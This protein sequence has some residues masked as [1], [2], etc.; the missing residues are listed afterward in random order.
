MRDVDL[1]IY[2][3]DGSLV[4]NLYRRGVATDELSVP[5]DGKDER[6]SAVA[7]GLYFYAVR[8]AG[9]AVTGKMLLLR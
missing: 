1:S 3:V 6:G 7:S 4:R 8:S 2:R 5:W 9:R